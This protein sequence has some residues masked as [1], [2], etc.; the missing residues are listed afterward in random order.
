MFIM[1]NGH[2]RMKKVLGKSENEKDVKFTTPKKAEFDFYRA[3]N[4]GS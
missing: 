4:L 2:W 1:F 3:E